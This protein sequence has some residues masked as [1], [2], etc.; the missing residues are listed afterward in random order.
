MLIFLKQLV[1]TA[2]IVHIKYRGEYQISDFALAFFVSSRIVSIVFTQF[3]S[4]ALM[5]GV[6]P[7]SIPGI[8]WFN[9]EQLF[10]V[11]DL[12]GK[13]LFGFFG[14]IIQNFKLSVIFL[15]GNTVQLFYDNKI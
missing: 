9:S 6:W 2:V 4:I 11:K 3:F 15:Y 5:R 13:H 1:Q 8:N 14:T 7:S 12:P 10:V